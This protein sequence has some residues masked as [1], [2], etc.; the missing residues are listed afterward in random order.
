MKV[1]FFHKLENYFW[2]KQASLKLQTLS[3][4]KCVRLFI[5]QKL[6]IT[7]EKWNLIFLK[8]GNG[9]RFVFFKIITRCFKFYSLMSVPFPNTA[10]AVFMRLRS[11]RWNSTK[12]ILDSVILKRIAPVLLSPVTYLIFLQDMNRWLKDGI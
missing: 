1:H 12:W 11:A 8:R 10:S 6:G 9:N 5:F 3:F 4:S 2:I 7:R